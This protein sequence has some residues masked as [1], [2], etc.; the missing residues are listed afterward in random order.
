LEECSQ[1][2]NKNW[3]IKVIT[4]LKLTSYGAEL[5]ILRG[6]LSSVNEHKFSG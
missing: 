6:F 2:T 3:I 1:R 4:P 5:G